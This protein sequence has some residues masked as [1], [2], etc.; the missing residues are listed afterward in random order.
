MQ[1]PL[2]RVNTPVSLLV[3]VRP[4][5]DG[6]YTAQAVGLP[7]IQ[8]TASTREGAIQQVRSV[9][10][11]WLASGQL[12]Q[13][14]LPQENPLL[15]WFGWAKDDPDYD[16]YLEEIRRFREEEDQRERQELGQSEC[17]DSSSTPTT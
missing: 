14:E 15:K 5:A 2:Q 13:L 12:V 9:L 17:S 7:D 3:T 8:A 16:L 6:Q 1:P 11:A 10:S 4:E